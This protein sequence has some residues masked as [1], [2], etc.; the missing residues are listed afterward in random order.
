[1][2]MKNKKQLKKKFDKWRMKNWM[3]PFT[4]DDLFNWIYSKMKPP[5][6][7][8]LKF[9]ELVKLREQKKK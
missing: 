9:S 1:M 2:N 7:P 4:T 5:K 8:K 3:Y 6:S